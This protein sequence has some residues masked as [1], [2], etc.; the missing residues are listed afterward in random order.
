MKLKQPINPFG[1]A[2]DISNCKTFSEA[3]EVSKLNYT[4]SKASIYAKTEIPNTINDK[5]A[6]NLV[7]FDN[8]YCPVENNYSTYRIDT[9]QQF[10]IVK[11]NYE[12]VQNNVAF[13]WFDNN[14]GRDGLQLDKAGYFSY[15]G[16]IFISVKLNNNYI[17]VG[18]DD[19]ENYLVFSNSHD[20]SNAVRILFTP[21]R[22]ICK[23]TLVSAIKTSDNYV[24]FKHTKNVIQSINT[25]SEVL[26]ITKIKIAET[27]ELYNTLYKKAMYDVD[28]LNY[29][30]KNIFNDEEIININ[31]VTNNDIL[32]VFNRSSDLADTISVNKLN[33]FT[34]I[35]EYYVSGYGQKEIRGTAWGAYNA[36]TGY[37][38]NVKNFNNSDKRTK[39][40]LFGTD[41]NAN[42]NALKLIMN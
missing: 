1:H 11:G 13:S 32:K 24:S 15:G 37:I 31:K 20:G 41:Y 26:G 30:S 42:V 27:N 25:A 12:I 28:V 17:K 22:I 23:N 33:K 8:M 4:V 10:G 18:K 36:V 21:I 14:I 19:I 6:N 38:S 29:L 39:D 7:A 34:D 35:C 16:M 5:N 2:V 3:M 40:I 9:G